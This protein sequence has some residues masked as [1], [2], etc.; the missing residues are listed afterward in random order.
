MRDEGTPLES[1]LPFPRRRG[2]FQLAH[3]S[4]K[5]RGSLPPGSCHLW[6]SSPQLAGL[7]GLSSCLTTTTPNHAHYYTFHLLS[8]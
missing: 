2:Y 4:S 3:L 8:T 7:P 5:V 1:C 6:L